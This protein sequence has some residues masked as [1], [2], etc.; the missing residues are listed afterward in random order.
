MEGFDQDPASHRRRLGSQARRA[1]KW[2]SQTIHPFRIPA[3]IGGH[4]ARL[5]VRARDSPRKSQQRHHRRDKHQS[6]TTEIESGHRLD[7]QHVE[8]ISLTLKSNW[9]RSAISAD[10]GHLDPAA[11]SKSSDHF[12]K[13]ESKG[14]AHGIVSANRSR[15]LPSK[16]NQLDGIQH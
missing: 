13:I 11:T 6:N 1:N 3:F 16:A 15:L 9:Q 8:S 12:D 10:R 4:E 2:Q 7:R 5:R 14:Q